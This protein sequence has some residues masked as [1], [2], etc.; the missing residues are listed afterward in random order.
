MDRHMDKERKLDALRE[1]YQAGEKKS[2]STI[3]TWMCT[4]IAIMLV[5]SAAMGSAWAYFTTYANAKGGITLNLGHQ[6]QIDEDFYDWEKIINLTSTDDSNPVYLRAKAYCAEYEV[7]YNNSSNWDYS[8]PEKG[9]DGWVYY[10]KT[11]EPGTS[12]FESGDELKVKIHNVPASG[13]DSLKDGKTFNVIV[14]YESLEVQY[15][16]DGIRQLSAKEAD[17]TRD[18]ET[19]RTITTLGGEE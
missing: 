15:D 5:M 17:W 7:T 18:L 11:L 12:L 6:E 16:E 13:D 2:K 4:A 3:R 9:G 8:D 10:T 1:G 19:T 14:V